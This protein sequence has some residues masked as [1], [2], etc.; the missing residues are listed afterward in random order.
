MANNAQGRFVSKLIAHDGPIGRLLED[1]LMLHAPECATKHRVG[2]SIRPIE[3][4]DAYGQ[5]LPD[6]KMTGP[7]RHFV[8]R[9][10]QAASHAG[11]RP[12]ARARSRVGVQ[13]D[14][15]RQIEH[16]LDRRGDPGHQFNRGHEVRISEMCPA[17]AIFS[18]WVTA[19]EEMG[20]DRSRYRSRG[21]A[22]G[23]SP[24]Q[25]EIHELTVALPFAGI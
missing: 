4:G 13:V 14:T 25:S 22:D 18:E 12:L 9:T 24:A 10:D 17:T 7:P 15:A 11:D 21:I 20:E 3:L 6:A 1:V 23:P 5:R 19:S 8:A 16:A 2:E